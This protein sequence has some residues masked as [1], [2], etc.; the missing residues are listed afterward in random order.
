MVELFRISG[1]KRYRHFFYGSTQ[2]TLD[3]MRTALLRDYPDMVIAGM[4]APP[5]RALTAEE[6]REITARINDARP[7]FIWVGLGAPKQEEWMYDHRGKLDA[8]AVGVGA[9]FDYLAGNIKRAPRLM[10]ALCLEWLYRL[11]QD[12]KRLWRRYVTTNAKFLRYIVR[13]KLTGK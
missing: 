13:E 5:F 9:G 11:M 6:D 1:Q 12:P 2:Q 7:D 10:Q 3:D 8:V 4:Y